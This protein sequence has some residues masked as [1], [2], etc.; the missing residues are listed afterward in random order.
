MTEPRKGEK[1]IPEIAVLLRDA[2]PTLREIEGEP[3]LRKR[4]NNIRNR[5]IAVDELVTIFRDH[6][7]Q[8]RLDEL[9]AEVQIRCKKW[10][11]QNGG[12]LP[13]RKG[14]RPTD[15]QKK[16][17]IAV[18]VA[19]ALRAQTGKRKSV[20]QAVRHVH[21]TLIFNGKRRTVPVP[22]IR[23]YYYDPDSEWRRV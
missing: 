10:K 12:R 7:K 16:I 14:G 22:T 8:D 3:D 2:Q 4:Q 6:E 11:Q 9:P 23:D 21:E 20:T 17:W 15:E 5:D 18:S 1:Y 13:R 19:E